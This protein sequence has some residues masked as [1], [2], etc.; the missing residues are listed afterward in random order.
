M[1]ISILRLKK[2]CCQTLMFDLRGEVLNSNVYNASI[3]FKCFIFQNK[4]VTEMAIYFL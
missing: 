2:T 3:I 4:I 1:F